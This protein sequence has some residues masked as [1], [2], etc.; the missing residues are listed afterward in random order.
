MPLLL[1]PV[2]MMVFA[3]LFMRKL[4]FDLADEVWDEGDTL[5]VRNMGQEERIP[6]TEIINLSYMSFSNPPRV[7]LTLRRPGRFGKEVAFCAQVRWNPFAKSPIIEELIER[8]DA[9]RRG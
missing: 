7:T 2:F 3:Y 5:R 8:I 4:V 1:V 9:K 6:L